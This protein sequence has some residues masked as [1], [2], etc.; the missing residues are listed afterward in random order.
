MAKRH[1]SPAQLRNLSQYKGMTDEEFD[2]AMGN[3]PTSKTS[4]EDFEKKVKK[5]MLGFEKDYD[6]SDMKF[7]DTET[8]QNLCKALVTLEDYEKI[9][10]ELRGESIGKNLTMIDKLSS[11]MSNIRK[12]VSRMQEDLK[13]TRKIRKSTQEESARA[14]LARQKKLAMEFYQ[15]KMFYVYCEKCVMLLTTTWF[16]YPTEKNILSIRCGRTYTNDEGKKIGTCGHINKITSRELLETRGTNHPEGF[17][18]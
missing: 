8:L 3:L 10:V 12:D 13:I 16:L 11:V 5:K 14:E 15:K 2:E 4:Y 9:L 18:F 17:D 7:N 1:S 6:L